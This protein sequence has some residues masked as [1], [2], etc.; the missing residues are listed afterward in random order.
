MKNPYREKA[1]QCR[2]LLRRAAMPEIREQLRIWARD[3]DELAERREQLQRLCLWRNRM[4]RAF[5]RTATA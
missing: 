2:D 4:R 5:R 3:F 1:K